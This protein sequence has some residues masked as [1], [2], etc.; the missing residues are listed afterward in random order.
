VQ[1]ETDRAAA[2]DQISDRL[3]RS[4]G[5][6]ERLCGTLSSADFARSC[7]L[8]PAPGPQSA[9]IVAQFEARLAKAPHQP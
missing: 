5:R 9:P 2:F 4:L 6:L 3:A 8:P 1:R 7:H